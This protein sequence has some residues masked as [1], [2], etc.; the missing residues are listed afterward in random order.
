MKPLR[1]TCG[2]C[3]HCE[4]IVQ[5]A[6]NRETNVKAPLDPEPDPILGNLLVDERTWTFVKLDASVIERA[7][8]RREPLYVNH[9]TT[10]KVLNANAS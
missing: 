2:P 3:Q 10:C 8:T 9:L 6:I 4:Q 7:I 1:P 5:W